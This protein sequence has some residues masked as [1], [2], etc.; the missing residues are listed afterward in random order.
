MEYIA[1]CAKLTTQVLA[2]LSLKELIR[3]IAT[4]D[5]PSDSDWPLLW[6]PLGRSHNLQTVKREPSAAGRCIH[7]D[8]Y[9]TS[10]DLSLVYNE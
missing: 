4:A 10:N 6:A 2:R 8:L 5:A 9:T 7:W 3:P 1:A